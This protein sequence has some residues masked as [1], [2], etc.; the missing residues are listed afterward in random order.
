MSAGSDAEEPMDVDGNETQQPP[1]SRD[2]PPKDLRT[3]LQNE[4]EVQVSAS[5]KWSEDNL[6]QKYK[7]ELTRV[8]QSWSNKSGIPVEFDVVHASEDGN[9]V[10]KIKPAS[11]LNHLQKLC[12][13]TLTSKDGKIV[14][15]NSIF[16]T[17]PETQKPDYASMNVPSSFVSH[18]Q[19][20]QV[21]LGE[22]SR[23]SSSAA[24]ST[25]GEETCTCSLPVSH[26]LYVSHIYK[27]EMKRIEKENGVDIAAEVMVTLKPQNQKDADPHK[28]LSD[29]TSLVQKSL[30][31]SNGTTIPLKFVDK[32]DWRDTLKIIQKNENKLLLTLSSEEMI[33]C[34]P[35]QSQVAISKSL[36]TAQ[37]TFTN[38]SRIVGESTWASQDTPLTIR[39]RIKDPLADA[40]LT[41]EENHWMLITTSFSE[42][43]AEIKMKFD[44]DF[45]TSG[46]SQ[47]KVDIR[48]RYRSAGGNASMESHA[49]RALLHLCQKIT[50]SPLG[51]TQNL[52]ASWFNGSL[53]NSDY[54]SEGDASGPASDGKPGNSMN[55]SEAA[56]GGAATDNEDKT[57]PIC[58][59]TFT[60]KKSLK[61]KHGFCEEC[62]EQAKKSMGPI[63]PLCKDV[64]G[65]IEGDQPDGNMSLTTSTMSLPGFS[66]CGTIVI[67]YNIRSG[68]QTKKHPNPGQHYGGIH[69]TAYLP[70]N[71]EGR[72][73]LKL[74]KKAFDQR[75][76]FTIG[77]SRTTGLDNQVTWNDIHHKTSTTGGPQNFGYPDPDYL[78]RVREELKAK[79]I[80]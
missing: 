55:N 6:P 63:C 16:L 76:I 15:V 39:M 78:S 14:T 31:E 49:V 54:Q 22:Q 18:P 36:N 47:G 8:L 43:I 25:A 66:H 3:S 72:E 59:D 21:Q 75:L 1:G 41:M 28:A 9:A 71:S 70:D 62:L 45:Q 73:V 10:M 57:C 17:P 53:K 32:E 68:K 11:A 51:F 38:T 61:C 69:R 29:F 34:G 74:L 80:K 4:D 24:G 64:F 19:N 26:F 77:T 46:I 33:I 20:E 7:V 13:Q 5:V 52:G 2:E 35:N 23:F 50:T 56:T 37:K 60:N 44:V 65:K 40:G 79:G 30:A 42:K 58:M 27:E 48:A 67:D 12:G